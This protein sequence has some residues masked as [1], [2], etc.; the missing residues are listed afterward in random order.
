[1]DKVNITLTRQENLARFHVPKGT[2]VTLDL[3]LEY[4]PCVVA[5][6]VYESNS[7]T[8][9]EAKK[10]QAVAAR[11][12]AIAHMK[13]G[14]I[15]DDTANYQ[16]VEWKEFASIPN[17]VQAVLDTAGQVLMC[18]GQL[19]TAW[20]SNSNGGR[21]KRSD[22]AWSSYKPWT[23]AQDDPW[24]VSAR[25][26]W[27]ECKASH[28]VGMSQMGAAYAASIGIPYTDILHFYYAGSDIVAGYGESGIIRQKIGG[29]YMTAQQQKIVDFCVSKL[30]CGYIYGATGWVCTAA[31][32][33]QQVAQYPEH[34]DKILGIGAKWDG[35]Q[36]FDCAQ[37]VKAAAK[38]VGVTMP[39]G[40]TSQY[41]KTPNLWAR[42]GQIVNGQL[43]VDAPGIILYR[44]D[45]KGIAQHTGIYIGG[46][47]VIEAKGAA[48]GV[49]QTSLAAGAWTDYGM[50]AGVPYEDAVVD[51]HVGEPIA[52]VP[53]SY[54]AEV[55]NV[56]TGLNFRSTPVNSTNTILL[57]PL[58]AV[59]EVLEDNCGSGMCKARY[60]GKVGYC[61][62]SY[63]SQIV[64]EGDVA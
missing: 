7:R 33:Q 17:S 26:K 47:V 36:C 56:K 11:T 34:A 15:L 64:A 58:G 30:G 25:V 54:F 55:V 12:Y 2:V 13:S 8:P 18:Q 23:V 57:L 53:E 10:A 37:L 31:R 32:R 42:R 45:A 50:L 61:T 59:V 43:P 62:R 6:E 5:S 40:A 4:L 3:E 39:S 21:T 9:M 1:M 20:Y 63:L 16:A 27:G 22:E 38:E 46:G 14:T 35:K 41:V 19:I 44:L 29:E 52:L 28:G 51:A 48:Y 24:D 60:L 49:V